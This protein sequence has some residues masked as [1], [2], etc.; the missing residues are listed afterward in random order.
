MVAIPTGSWTKPPT[1]EPVSFENI[2]KKQPWYNK[3][4]AL[5]KSKTAMKLVNAAL[6]ITAVGSLD[7]H[8]SW[9]AAAHP[10]FTFTQ[11]VDRSYSKAHALPVI[12]IP[13]GTKYVATKF[14]TSNGVIM[15]QLEA[16]ECVVGR[17]AEVAEVKVFE[18]D[19]YNLGQE[20]GDR[21][22]QK[23]IDGAILINNSRDQLFGKQFDWQSKPFSRT[24]IPGVKAEAHEGGDTTV[25]VDVTK[26]PDGTV[27]TKVRPPVEKE[28]PR[29]PKPLPTAYGEW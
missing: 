9:I 4:E 8:L 13:Q 27:K 5:K 23:M 20:W 10:Y 22:A 17:E 19:V 15:V 3:I 26:E 18:T 25:T 1:S 7:E 28:P 24:S 21:V 16:Y 14:R 11:S 29:T 12:H 6:E 2:E